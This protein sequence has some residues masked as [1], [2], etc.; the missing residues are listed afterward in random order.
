MQLPWHVMVM[1][2]ASLMFAEQPLPS[3]CCAHNQCGP[4]E[5]TSPVP[6]EDGYVGLVNQ[7][8]TCYQNSLLQQLFMIPQLRRQVGPHVLLFS[9]CIFVLCTSNRRVSVVAVLF[10]YDI[11]RCWRRRPPPVSRPTSTRRHCHACAGS[12]SVCSPTWHC[13]SKLPTTRSPS[14]MRAPMSP[15]AS[16][17]WTPP[18]HTKTTPTSS[19]TC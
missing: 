11:C 19:T 17:L 4:V 12:F 7:G 16:S 8:L 3:E 18:P 15:R 2:G 1:S 10:Y 5:W 9:L 14:W 13:L 6:G